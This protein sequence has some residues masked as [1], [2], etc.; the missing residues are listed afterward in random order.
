MRQRITNNFEVEDGVPSGG[1]SSGKGILIA[2]QRGALREL[3]NGHKVPNGAFVEG[4]I[5][6]AID[7]LEFFQD[8]A[9]GK[10]ACVENA[11]AIMLLNTALQSLDARTARRTSE[12]VEGTHRPDAHYE[13]VHLVTEREPETG[14]PIM[15]AKPCTHAVP[16]VKPHDAEAGMLLDSAPRPGQSFTDVLLAQS[17]AVQA[18]ILGSEERAE[19]FR[20]MGVEFWKSNFAAGGPVPLDELVRRQGGGG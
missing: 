6:A 9:G 11:T 19:R 15:R 14:E 4:V 12:G 13:D 7:R 3:G 5:Q 16:V 2:W 20:R 17:N 8:A 18:S 10:F 1:M